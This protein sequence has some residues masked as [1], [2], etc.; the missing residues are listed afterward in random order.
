MKN[1]SIRYSL[2]LL[3]FSIAPFTAISQTI[4]SYDFESGLQS[5]TDGGSDSGLNT[6]SIYASNGSRS[7]YSKDNDTSQNYT[8]SPTL[9]LSAYGSVDFSFSF[10]GRGI[11]SG[12][13]FSLQYFDGSNWS[14]IKTY[15]LGTDF[16][17]NNYIYTFYQTIN[18]GLASNSQFRFS[19]TADSNGEYSYFDDIL[20][21]VSAPEIDVTGNGIS[22]SNG[23]VSPA[24]SDYTAF[25]TSNSG[26]LV[27]R[28][29]T[30]NNKGG[31]NLTIANIT[32]SNTT[33]FSIVAPF[34]SSPVVPSTGSTTFTVQ[35]TPATLGTKTCTVTI[36]NNDSD[37][38]AF[39]F[40]IDARSEQN[41]FDS[42][43]DG[44]LDNVDI[45]DD[46]DGI[47]DSDEE[48]SCSASSISSTTNYKFLNETF[49]EGNRTTINTT[50][51]AITTYCYEDG[52]NGT[53][54][55]TCPSLNNDD[56]SD[57][58]YV[59]YY[60]AGDGDGTDDTPNAEVASWADNYWYTGEDH[61]SGD[62]NGRMAMFNASYDPGTFYSATI[63]G[64]LPN[65]PITYSFWVLNL[66][67]TT[68]P[69]IATRLRPDIL[70]EF[71]DVNNNVLASITTGDIP[72]SVNGDPAA[73]WHQFTA[74]LTFNVSEF[75]VY[76]INNEVGGAGNDL[77]ID[78]IVISQT[79]CDTDGDGVAD[80]FD[81]DSD[82]DGI[83]GVVEIGLG[84]YSD[85]N[86]TLTNS[87]SWVD[88]NNNGMHDLSEGYSLLDSDGDG[89]PNY[90]DLDSDNDTIFDVD[91]SG[92]TNSSSATYQNGDGDITGDGVG[93]GPDTDAVRETDINSDG[94]SEFFTDG[95]LDLYDFFEGG[96]FATGYGNSNQGATGTGWENYVVDTD[97]DNI[98]DYLDV[99]SDGS[100]FDISH[101]LY[102]S[103]DGNNDGLIDD[104]NDAEGDGII[105]LFDTDDTVFGSPR[106]LDRKLQLYFDGRNDYAAETSVINGWDEATI[107]SW[108][109]IDPSAS[110]NQIIVGQDAF[111][112]QLNADKTITS[113]A[114][115]YTISSSSSLLTNQW[116]HVAATYSCDCID[117]VFKLYV[118]GTEIA[119]TAT[120]SGSLN[121]DTSSFT[122]GRKP[123]TDSNYFHGYVDEVRVFDKALSENELHKMIHQEIE[124][125]A[126][127]TRGTIIPL[128]ITDFVDT[129]NITP[130]NWS[131][132]QRYYRLDTY[133]D[134]IID[135]LTTAS[136][137]VSAGA[138]IYNSK[139]IE[140][141]TAPLPYVTTSSCNGDWTDSSNW[142]QGNL[143]DISSTA[144]D[145]AIIQIKGNIH[146]SIARSTVG[147]ILDSGSKLEVNGDSGLFNSWYL[148][149]DGDIDLEGESQ[150]IQTDDSI[151]DATS[152]GT[153]ER[154]Q[155]GT[156]DTFTYNYWSSPVGLAN[157]STNNNSYK[158][159]DIFTNVN[160]I[161]SGYNGSASPIGIAD[162]WIW[163]FNNQ[164]SDNYSK[165]QHVRSTGTLLA[166]EGFT[167]K[168]PGTGSISTPQN[169]VLNGKPNN[170]DINLTISSG[171]DYLVGNPYPSAI[172]A[173][174]FIL[175]N[176]PTIAG[177]GSTTGTLYFW[178]HWGGGS[179]ILRE[180]QGGYATYS[181]SGGV[182]AASKGTNDPD[183]AT[184][185]I[186]TKTPG[187]YIP[188]A[189]G[190][191]VTAEAAGTVKFNNGQRV[192]QIEDGSNSLFVKSS[193]T[194]KSK[195]NS[196]NKTNTGDTRMKLRIGF[197]SIN[198]IH[199]QLLIT[200]DE[201]ASASYDWGYDSKYIDTQ[202]DDMYW[203][204]NN[205][206]FTIQGIDDI[207]DQTIIPLGLHTK[208]DGFN[209]IAIDK[210]ENTPDNL[211]IYLHD[212][213]LDIYQN[214]KQG[215]Y[216]TYLT[217]G[218][219][220]NRFEITFSKAQKTL[221]INDTEINQIEVYFSNEENRIVINNPASKRIESVEMLNI[222]GQSLFKFQTSTNDT[223]LKYN[224]SQI[225]TGNYVLKIQTEY[226]TISKKVLI[227]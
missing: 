129:S 91:E 133:K 27:T 43:G 93:D 223:H 181:L 78:D 104:T 140:G 208:K 128:D 7:I 177:A 92:A 225:K 147:L 168:G 154:D 20:I 227:K 196:S 61:T 126:G 172:D 13:G 69:G 224:A 212:K 94:V 176:G 185:G 146:T 207:N 187:R 190:F 73:S 117:G 204:I 84:N 54:T 25:G 209:S 124:N 16:T 9:D 81:L 113:Y 71:R 197:N 66:D 74:N 32:L 148:K 226:G 85:G 163:K 218:E 42:D 161:T 142:E 150:L 191:F 164:Q 141:Q 175:D 50:Y 112:L 49:G 100:T 186:P 6:N 202:I 18:S 151:L 189:Q 3:L 72:P 138:R 179:H 87:G 19:S 70:V 162:Y 45:D 130:L 23:D 51:D 1:I 132:L 5:W 199:R 40:D 143:W 206:K 216:K 36:T 152:S 41:F 86:A 114:D 222:L 219:Y 90:L 165:W 97:N 145:C 77:A 63:V 55:T 157:N 107:M 170:G 200:V 80:V 11:D 205:E 10:I 53:S 183:V 95:I 15:V 116:T 120:S 121:A 44:I 153:L 57:G 213:E 155:Q 135:D 65:V 21:Q 134:N 123:D 115:G 194:K 149:L 75:Y 64:A 101:T 17:S 144:P 118:N 210:L 125:N 46:N 68:A 105:D 203:L 173:V 217:A 82:N 47:P 108:I 103:L 96:T 33:D 39:Q 88:A 31:S 137:D 24:I 76:F 99:T 166:G 136:I 211:E 182:P 198:E 171:N 127:V 167:M 30:I 180:Y 221:G 122:I 58:E 158:L 111:Y 22:I 26:T 169:Y 28:T 139:I 159:P 106:D 193:N 8:T 12:E 160:F 184:G 35:F 48:S 37:E 109:R 52:T 56:L 102:A 215:N 38:S 67:T 62:T 79:L 14:T 59:V 60:K 89:T 29:Y 83:P 201:N 98:P 178:E 4:A 131:S 2:M 195:A 188:V 192:F 174:Q 220:L 156:A 34:Y 214:L 119:S 110:G